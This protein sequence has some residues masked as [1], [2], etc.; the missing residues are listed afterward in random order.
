MLLIFK[1]IRKEIHTMNRVYNF[2]TGPSVL[3]V[4]GIRASIY[5][6]M[7]KVGIEKLTQFMAEFERNN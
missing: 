3:P 6:A 1:I 4:G 5:N 2:S 7:P